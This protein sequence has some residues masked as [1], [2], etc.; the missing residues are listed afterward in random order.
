[1]PKANG[2]MFGNVNEFQ[3]IDEQCLWIKTLMRWAKN[4][5]SAATWNP[6]MRLSL[7]GQ[8]FHRIASYNEDIFSCE[9]PRL[10]GQDWNVDDFNIRM[11]FRPKL[12]AGMGTLALVT[13]YD[14]VHTSIDSQAGNISTGVAPERTAEWRN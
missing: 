1:M 5:P 11:T 14:F 6:T 3:K 13:R 4:I 7:A 9:Y 10:I 2:K 12:P 8:Y